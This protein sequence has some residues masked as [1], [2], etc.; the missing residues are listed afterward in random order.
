MADLQDLKELTGEAAAVAAE[1]TEE[2]TP[3]VDDLG[4]SYATG[5]RKDAIA[6]VWVKPGSG[7]VTVNGRD[8]ETYFARPTLRLIVNQ[9]FQVVGRENQYDVVATVKGGGLSGQ[10]GAVKHGISKALQQAEPELR[11]ALKAAGFLTRDSRV[12]ERKKY[13]KAK[14]RRSFQFSKR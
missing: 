7:K 4:R 11:A 6:R 1:V 8:Q 2:R 14:A 9:P 13:G 3:V 12:V 5:K 10:A